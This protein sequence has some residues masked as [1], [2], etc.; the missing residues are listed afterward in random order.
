MAGAGPRCLTPFGKVAEGGKGWTRGSRR[1]FSAGVFGAKVAT[2][3]SARYTRMESAAAAAAI[4]DPDTLQKHGERGRGIS[5]RM[6]RMH[7][8]TQT[9]SSHC[10]SSPGG[11]KKQSAC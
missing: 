1:M 3:T 6:Q 2:C 9:L 10:W 8:V 4:L 7:I 5:H 11:R